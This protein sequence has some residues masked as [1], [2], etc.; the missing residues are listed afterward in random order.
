MYRDAGIVQWMVNSSFSCVYFCRKNWSLK[1]MN[2]F[3]KTSTYVQLHWWNFIIAVIFAQFI[4]VKYH[5]CCRL[6]VL[7]SPLFTTLD[8]TLDF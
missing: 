8:R 6:I 7:F 2:L 1:S 3:L 4:F 5:N